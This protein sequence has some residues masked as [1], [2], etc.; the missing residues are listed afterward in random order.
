MFI[1][2]THL[3][4][5][6]PVDEKPMTRRRAL[7]AICTSFFHG[8]SILLPLLFS[9]FSFSTFSQWVISFKGACSF[10][11]LLKSGM[12]QFKV[13]FI[14]SSALSIIWWFDLKNKNLKIKSIGNKV[15][16]TEDH[17]RY[18][19]YMGS[20]EGWKSTEILKRDFLTSENTKRTGNT[21]PR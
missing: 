6:Q 20:T 2:T 19:L 15:E 10:Q 9:L 1:F 4:L 8:G 21:L 14:A 17:H 5:H 3:W 13:S 12:K 18:H 7:E 16:M 11:L